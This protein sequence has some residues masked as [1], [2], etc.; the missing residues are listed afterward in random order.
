MG[1]TILMMPQEFVLEEQCAL[2]EGFARG[3]MV[4][5]SEGQSRGSKHPWPRIMG[6]VQLSGR[7]H[8][9]RLEESLR[10]RVRTQA[11]WNVVHGAPMR[12]RSVAWYV[13]IASEGYFTNFAE[14]YQWL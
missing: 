14:V 5:G 1:V 9:K 13:L 3:K 4:D 7:K 6:G 12:L 11:A 8:A 10:L 2:L